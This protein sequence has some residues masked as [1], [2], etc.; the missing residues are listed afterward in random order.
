MAIKNADFLNREFYDPGGQK[1]QKAPSE[2]VEKFLEITTIA[3]R[4]YV[5]DGVMTSDIAF[6][7]GKAAIEA[8]GIDKESLDYIIN[9]PRNMFTVPALEAASKITFREKDY[10]RAADY[11]APKFYLPG[12]QA[13]FVSLFSR[14]PAWRGRR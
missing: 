14:P 3:E 5:K 4:R 10:N 1:L 12:S 11:W 9:Q 6:W 2:I 7:A 13:R 8:A